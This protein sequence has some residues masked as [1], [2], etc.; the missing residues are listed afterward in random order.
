MAASIDVPTLDVSKSI[1]K[2]DT[3]ATG[4]TGLSQPFF[5]IDGNLTVAAGKRRF[6]NDTGRTLTIAKV[7]ASVNTAPTTQSIICDVNIDGVT[8]WTTQAN[9]IAIT[10]TTNTATTTSF[11]VTTIADGHYF[12][13]D[14][15]QTGTGTVGADLTVTIALTG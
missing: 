7:R 1:A 3:G 9:R 4:A 14:V 13:V 2:G 5:W 11:D 10:A 15:D 6:Y 8:I 12:T